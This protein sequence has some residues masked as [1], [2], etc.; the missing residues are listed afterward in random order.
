MSYVC[1]ILDILSVALS[2]PK[3]CIFENKQLIMLHIM[4][5]NMRFFIIGLATLK[6]SPNPAHPLLVLAL[7]L[8][9]T[10]IDS[11][12]EKYALQLSVF[13]RHSASAWLVVPTRSTPDAPDV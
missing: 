6:P 12:K 13:G 8:D 7:T 4:P 2:V 11:L 10:C 3:S 1:D 5:L 9:P